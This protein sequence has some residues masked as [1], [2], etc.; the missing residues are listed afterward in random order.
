MPVQTPTPQS[1]PTAVGAASMRQAQAPYTMPT[2]VV[3]CIA[4]Y[5]GPLDQ[6]VLLHHTSAAW[7]RESGARSSAAAFCDAFRQQYAPNSRAMSRQTA[8]RIARI[9]LRKSCSSDGHRFYTDAGVVHVH[10]SARRGA[11]VV[12]TARGTLVPICLRRKVQ[13][14]P[15]NALIYGVLGD[16]VL[17]AQTHL[18][19]RI[20]MGCSRGTVCMD[21]TDPL[22]PCPFWHTRGVARG[23]ITCDDIDDVLAIDGANRLWRVDLLN[24]CMFRAAAFASAA[25][26][27]ADGTVVVAVRHTLITHPHGKVRRL[28]F[29]VRALRRVDERTLLAEGAHQ[30]AIVTMPNLDVSSVRRALTAIIMPSGDVVPAN[31]QV[32]IDGGVAVAWRRQQPWVTV[33]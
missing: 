9:T 29:K 2:D 16:T 4:K 22:R 33:L 5:L 24:N 10:L 31:M 19:D 12:V 18:Q 20:I 7:R 23:K 27:A 32:S 26:H 11:A 30:H 8:R 21:V 17:T 3:R 6:L 15:V 28:A 25:T 1:G 13:F 14:P